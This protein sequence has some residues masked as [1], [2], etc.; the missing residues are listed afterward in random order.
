MDYKRTT[1]VVAVLFLALFV[2]TSNGLASLSVVQEKLRNVQLKVIHEKLKLI[3]KQV[4]DINIVPE[5]PEV[6]APA[7]E[8]ELSAEELSVALQGQIRVL[9]E[10]IKNLQPKALEE[11]TAR[12]EKRVLEINQALRTATGSK[13]QELQQ[14]LALVLSDY[15]ML[16]A[17]TRRLV[18][19][20]I[21]SRQVAIL[22]E[23]I[24]TMQQ[25]LNL[26]QIQQK[27]AAGLP[28]PAPAAEDRSTI[29]YL[30]DSV[31]KV[32]LKLLQA[33]LKAVQEKILQLKGN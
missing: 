17:S 21:K 20:A 9:E 33:Q 28:P 3:Q 6:K 23:Q 2:G 10:I 31:E 11:E 16:Q 12:L 19:D 25:R 26:A 15:Q 32:K 18:D 29:N 22:K 30:K 14:E 7:P 1:V 24:Q 27:A 4:L 5:V 13:L 8:P